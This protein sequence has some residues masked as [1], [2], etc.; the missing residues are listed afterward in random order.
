MWKECSLLGICES[1]RPSWDLAREVSKVTKPGLSDFPFP[2][3][4]F[5]QP[6]Y[7]SSWLKYLEALLIFHPNRHKGTLTPTPTLPECICDI[8]LMELSIFITHGKSYILKSTS[9]IHF[10]LYLPFWPPRGW[11]LHLHTS[12][13]VVFQNHTWC[14]AHRY[15]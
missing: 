4:T 11:E 3:P 14:L 10:I 1:W 12:T 7:I 5:V 9:H 15:P 2:N 8:F 13:F 6:S